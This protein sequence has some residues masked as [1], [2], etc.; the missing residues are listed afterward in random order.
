VEA[1]GVRA[2]T[3]IPLPSDDALSRTLTVHA[4]DLLRS[5]DVS[6][7][8]GGPVM[9]WCG[10]RGL[11]SYFSGRVRY[12]KCRGTRY[13]GAVLRGRAALSGGRRVCAI[14]ISLPAR[15]IGRFGGVGGA[16]CVDN[17]VGSVPGLR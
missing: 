5:S 17:G 14:W 1:E 10:G 16:A 6:A 8:R 12:C 15:A 2:L 7:I 11:V 4:R 3:R 13:A 9:G